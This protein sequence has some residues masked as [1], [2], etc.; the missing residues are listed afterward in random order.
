[1]DHKRATS[2]KK[3]HGEGR[4]RAREALKPHHQR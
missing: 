1:M 4:D 2:E 3:Q